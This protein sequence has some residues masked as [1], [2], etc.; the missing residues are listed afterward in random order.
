MWIAEVGRGGNLKLD[1]RTLF[2]FCA[3][4]KLN[5]IYKLIIIMVHLHLDSFG[6]TGGAT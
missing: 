5:L 6:S 2:V 3:I 1:V 4:R